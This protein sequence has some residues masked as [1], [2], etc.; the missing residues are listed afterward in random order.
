ML[1]KWLRMRQQEEQQQSIAEENR[2]IP[3]SPT[4][5]VQNML[6]PSPTAP[7]QNIDPNMMELL[8]ETEQQYP[9]SNEPDPGMV[10]PT[11]MTS[12]EASLDI[13]PM[14][15]QPRFN[16]NFLPPRGVV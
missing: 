16:P 13:D 11:T 8:D 5:G 10:L 15:Q 1:P 2:Q 12:G 7:P 9:Q 14:T 6:Q 4:E 3:A